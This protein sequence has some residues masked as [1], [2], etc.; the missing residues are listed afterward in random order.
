MEVVEHHIT[1]NFIY[2]I[3][4]KNEVMRR[5]RMEFYLDARLVRGRRAPFIIFQA[6]FHL[7]NS[8]LVTFPFV[9]SHVVRP[10]RCASCEPWS[11]FRGGRTTSRNSLRLLKLQTP[12]YKR[13]EHDKL[14]SNTLW[15]WCKKFTWR[16]SVRR[17]RAFREFQG[18]LVSCLVSE[19]HVP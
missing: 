1:C 6:R 10:S 14:E 7:N 5:F 9:S 13:L 19:R 17:R 11:I 3:L 2:A 15:K 18:G 12:S 4:L 8:P 16:R